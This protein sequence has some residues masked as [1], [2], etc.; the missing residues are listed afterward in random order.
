MNI[1][2]RPWAASNGRGRSRPCPSPLP[3][4]RVA[5]GRCRRR[6]G[7]VFLIETTHAGEQEFAESRATVLSIVSTKRSSLAAM[8]AT[9]APVFE[10]EGSRVEQR[11]APGRR[12]GLG[13]VGVEH[14]EAL[15]GMSGTEVLTVQQRIDRASR[16]MLGEGVGE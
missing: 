9:L 13:Q 15:V 7:A 3:Q 6:P 8:V 12:I 11:D 16:R 10:N 4:P 1:P 14:L 2:R 5:E